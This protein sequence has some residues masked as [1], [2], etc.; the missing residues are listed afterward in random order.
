M[1]WSEAVNWAA[2]LSY[3]SY[4]D[5]R[6]PT[7]PGTTHGCINEGEMGHLFHTDGVTISSPDPFIQPWLPWQT[8]TSGQAFQ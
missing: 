6:L 1:T 8:D 2:N 7:T 4:N 3:G 5:W